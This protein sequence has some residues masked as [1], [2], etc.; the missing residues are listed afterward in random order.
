MV[1]N[2]WGIENYLTIN[3]SNPVVY[4]KRQRVIQYLIQG[5]LAVVGVTD[6]KC[7]ISQKCMTFDDERTKS[8]D[9]PLPYMFY[10]HLQINQRSK[11]S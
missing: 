1:N 4:L 2:L 6:E 7:I 10:L 5:G 8:I 3:S 11:Y 9:G